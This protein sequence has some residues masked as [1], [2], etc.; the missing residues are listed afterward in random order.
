MALSR[1]EPDPARMPASN[2]LEAA[3]A[4]VGVGTP[5]SRQVPRSEG[6]SLHG[7]SLHGVSAPQLIW[8]LADAFA[9]TEWGSQRTAPLEGIP[10]SDCHGWPGTQGI[11]GVAVAAGVIPL[12]CG[13][14]LVNMVAFV[15]CL[16]I[17]IQAG[18]PPV[19]WSEH[20]PRAKRPIE[21][22]I[23]DYERR[24]SRWD[25]MARTRRTSRSASA[26]R[27]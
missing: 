19:T 27:R 25:D 22:H 20:S 7:A 21:A 11:R 13:D 8:R 4:A 5:S 2:S 3:I 26:A 23:A 14:G 9:R 1:I 17:T 16:A 12:T 18:S 24:L 15:A 10:E 6:A